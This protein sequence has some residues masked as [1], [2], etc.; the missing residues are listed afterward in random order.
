MIDNEH[1]YLF[2]IKWQHAVLALVNADPLARRIFQ[3]RSLLPRGLVCLT[4][5][6]IFRFDNKLDTQQAK[7]TRKSIPAGDSRRRF[8]F[9]FG[10]LAR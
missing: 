3:I 4:L 2:R 6:W 10:N 5:G 1:R 7:R 9:H 8:P